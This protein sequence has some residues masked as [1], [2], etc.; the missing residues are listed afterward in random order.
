M[1]R[2][3][4]GGE[5]QPGPELGPGGSCGVHSWIEGASADGMVGFL[6]CAIKPSWRTTVEDAKSW[7]NGRRSR[8]WRRNGCRRRL[9]PR[10]GRGGDECRAASRAIRRPRRE[11]RLGPRRGGRNLPARGVLA[12]FSKPATSPGFADPS[13]Q[14]I[15]SASTG[16]HHGEGFESKKETPPSDEILYPFRFCP[17]GHFSVRVRVEVISGRDQSDQ[18]MRPI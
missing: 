11:R 3:V 13:K 1:D 14:R 7:R 5:G 2:A 12:I 15:R 8:D 4:D 17:Y 6:V 16:R 18:S 10:C 9:G